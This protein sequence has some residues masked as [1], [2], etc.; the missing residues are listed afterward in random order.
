VADYEFLAAPSEHPEGRMP[1]HELAEA[2]A[3]ETSRLSHQTRRMR[4]RGL[5]DRVANP[6]DRR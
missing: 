4:E 5:L 2:L 3:R 1:A 6:A